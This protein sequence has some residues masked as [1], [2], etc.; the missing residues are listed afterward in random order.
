MSTRA[1]TIADLTDRVDY[2]RGGAQ[3]MSRAGYVVHAA[4]YTIWA[5]EA[6]SDLD[7]MTAPRWTWRQRL[8]V[9][10]SVVFGEAV[11]AAV[12]WAAVLR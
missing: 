8:E 10:A 2:L 7:A 11:F 5:D 1:A 9:A 6:Q 12:L 4:D 3:R